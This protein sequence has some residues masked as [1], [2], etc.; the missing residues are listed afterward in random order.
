MSF[1][2]KLAF[3]KKK[4]PLDTDF[5][6]GMPPEQGFDQ[7][8]GLGG[9]VGKGNELGLGQDAGFDGNFGEQQTIRQPSMPKEAAQR[10]SMREV[11]ISVSGAQGEQRQERFNIDK[12]VELISSKIDAIRA[13]IQTINQ[14]LA[15]IERMVEDNRE[16]QRRTW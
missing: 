9:D 3:W 12:D 5:G 10:Y 16:R 6:M 13:E 14:R 2:G 7:E 11:P 4:E 8:L 1:F 15:N